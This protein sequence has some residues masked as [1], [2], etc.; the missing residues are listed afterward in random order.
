M[1]HAARHL[2]SCCVP[3]AGWIGL[4]GAP[5]NLSDNQSIGFRLFCMGS[6]HAILSVHIPCYAPSEFHVSRETPIACTLARHRS[7]SNSVLEAKKLS[8][9]RLSNPILRS[10]SSRACHADRKS[11]KLFSRA[12][13][14]AGPIP[15]TR[16]NPSQYFSSDISPRISCTTNASS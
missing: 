16:L 8:I 15:F 6:L 5:Q 9:V 7:R 12:C 13:T 1:P 10:W 3:T 2:R 14:L 4:V 11:P